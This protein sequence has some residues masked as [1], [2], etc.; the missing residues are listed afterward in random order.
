VQGIV[1]WIVVATGSL[2]FIYN[3]FISI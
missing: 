2:F 1:L 3:R